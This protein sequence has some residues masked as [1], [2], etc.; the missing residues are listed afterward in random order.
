MQLRPNRNETTK[1]ETNQT[2]EMI[3][4]SPF[5]TA[6]A[7]H[8]EMPLSLRPFPSLKRAFLS[9]S[10]LLR[11]SSLVPA[12]A[13]SSSTTVSTTQSDAGSQPKQPAYSS[14]PLQVDLIFIFY[15]ID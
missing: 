2:G 4:S 3:L 10:S 6:G 13:A 9:S 8:Y 14:P 1:E 5:T 11:S 15:L 12:M 7:H